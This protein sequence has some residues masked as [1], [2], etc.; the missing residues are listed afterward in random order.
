M[1]KTDAKITAYGGSALNVV[2]QATI[3]V[4]RQKKSYLLNCQIINENVHPLLGHKACLGMKLIAYLDNDAINKPQTGKGSVFTVNTTSP[5]STLITKED[6]CKEFP[7]VFSENCGLLD[8]PYHI[9]LDSSVQ[10]IQHCPRKVPIA[11]REQLKSELTE[12]TEKGIICPVTEP[13]Q[14]ISSLVCVPKKNGKLRICLDPKDLNS[15]ICRENYPLPT[16]EDISTRLYNA[17]VFTKLDVRNGFW[18]VPLDEESS[19]LTTFNTPFGRYRWLRMP[20]G[21]SSAPEVFQR[22]MHQLIEGLQGVEVIADDFVIIGFGTLHEDAI[23]DHDKNL[24]KFL[25]RCQ[26]YNVVLNSEVVI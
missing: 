6:L 25:Q 19:F 8:E 3:K 26:E 21:I 10:P 16:I 4:W 17:K 5:D 11:I 15:A 13:T 9:K 18:H 24:I 23:K 7:T 2:G 20:F 22:R 14:W 1:E 12:M